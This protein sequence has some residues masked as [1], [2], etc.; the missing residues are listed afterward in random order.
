MRKCSA[1]VVCARQEG[2]CRGGAD[3]L[4]PG[5]VLLRTKRPGMVKFV[6]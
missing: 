4:G 5:C 3:F 2:L 1:V 6:F